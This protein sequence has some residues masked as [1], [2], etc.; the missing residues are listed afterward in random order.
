VRRPL[1][2]MTLLLVANIILLLALVAI[3][4]GLRG[5]AYEPGRPTSEDVMLEYVRYALMA[6][7]FTLDVVLPFFYFRRR[8]SG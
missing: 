8:S 5:A 4:W 3:G 6:V 1:V 2:T 7:L